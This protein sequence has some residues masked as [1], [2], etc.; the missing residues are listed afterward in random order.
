[1]AKN[2]VVYPYK[3]ASKSGKLLASVLE[4]KRVNPDGD[5]VPKPNDVIINWGS[6]H[7]PIWRHALQKK[8]QVINHW[9]NVNYAIDKAETFRRFEDCGVRYPDI[10]A[11][12]RKAKT[13]LE[14]DEYVVGRRTLDGKDGDGIVFMKGMTDFEE[15]RLYTKYVKKTTEYRVYVM[16][17]AVIDCLEK[18]RDTDRLNAGTV[19]PFI[20]TEKNGWCFC[21]GNVTMP[22]QVGQQ[23][24]KAVEALGLVFGGVDVIFSPAIERAYVL[25]VNTAPSIFGPTVRLYAKALK[26][27]AET[28]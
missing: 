27:Y 1:M 24:I 8:G 12:I 26:Q 28:I 5:Y 25:E 4:C 20:R 2:L 11:S 15:C 18:R 21:R 22:R 16:D 13:W 23:A 19:D 10:T 6:G 7:T 14:D 3:M 17:G 9:Q